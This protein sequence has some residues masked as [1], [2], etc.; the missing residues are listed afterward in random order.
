MDKIIMCLNNLIYPLNMN[1]SMT[2]AKIF[3]CRTKMLK[4]KPLNMIQRMKREKEK[5]NIEMFFEHNKKR[6]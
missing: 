1:N 2:A 3:V 5:E 6:K 4:Q